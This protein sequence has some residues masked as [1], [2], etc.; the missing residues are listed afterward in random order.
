[1]YT[2]VCV[3]MLMWRTIVTTECLPLLLSIIFCEIESLLEYGT[4]SLGTLAS[5]RILLPLP[6]QLWYDRHAPQHSTFCVGTGDKSSGPRVYTIRTLLT[7]PFLQPDMTII[8]RADFTLL[9][10]TLSHE[11]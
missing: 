4:H 11:C 7:E 8:N 3:Y 10:L 2:C 6:P 5:P 1:M 9:F